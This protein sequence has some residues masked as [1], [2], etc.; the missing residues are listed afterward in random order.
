MPDKKMWKVA[1][2]IV[3]KAVQ[4]WSTYY[5]TIRRKR[6][7]TKK[8]KYW[9]LLLCETGV[10]KRIRHVTPKMLGEVGLHLDP[11]S[12]ASLSALESRKH[13]GF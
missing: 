5:G 3:V 9:M 8:K 4:T 7:Q 2:N 1:S 11:Q 13:Q 12:G 6:G 10:F